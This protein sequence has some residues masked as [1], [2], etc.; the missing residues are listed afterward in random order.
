VQAIVCLLLGFLLAITAAPSIHRLVTG[1][2][3]LLTGH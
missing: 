1:I 3:R 2:V